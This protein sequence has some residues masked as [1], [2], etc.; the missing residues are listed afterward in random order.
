MAKSVMGKMPT[1]LQF[2]EENGYLTKS[3]QPR[4]TAE[5]CYRFISKESGFVEAHTGLEDVEIETE[6]LRYCHRQHK[7]MKKKLWE[8]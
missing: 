5:I 7:P 8:K 2:C 1:Y 6:I 3:G 4:F